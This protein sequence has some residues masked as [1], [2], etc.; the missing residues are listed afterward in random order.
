[1]SA[2]DPASTWARMRTL[3]PRDQFDALIGMSSTATD[4]RVREALL[5]MAPSL[6]AEQRAMFYSNILGT[7]LLSDPDAALA[8]F[9]TLPAADQPAVL[10]RMSDMLLNA[11]PRRGADFLVSHAQNDHALGVAY[12]RIGTQWGSIN[13][14]EAAAW[15]N[16][17]PPGPALEYGAITF[18]AQIAERDPA[19]AMAWAK[20]RY[21][22]LESIYQN[23][24]QKDPAGADR[25]LDAADLPGDLV[26]KVR[27]SVAK[28]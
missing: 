2:A 13:P 24:W 23:L 21:S 17:Q 26:A 7:W 28:K 19:T 3:P 4:P 25:A 20:P 1:M 12:S 14:T 10:D 18:A 22:M 11:D 5:G 8:R 6:D 9:D 27:Q 16:A 15:L